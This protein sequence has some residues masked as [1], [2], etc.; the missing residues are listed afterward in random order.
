[1]PSKSCRGGCTVSRPR[2]VECL[3]AWSMRIGTGISGSGWRH[4]L[5]Q[6]PGSWR[7][8]RVS[9]QRSTHSPG[10]GPSR[11][12]G[13]EENGWILEPITLGLHPSG[14]SRTDSYQPEAQASGSILKKL[15]SIYSFALRAGIL[16]R[17]DSSVERSRP[18]A[19]PR[20]RPLGIAVAMVA[21]WC[22]RGSLRNALSAG[23]RRDACAA[24]FRRSFVGPWPGSPRLARPSQSVAHKGVGRSSDSR[25]GETSLLIK[26]PCRPTRQWPMEVRRP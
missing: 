14:D 13:V 21:D 17:R 8:S 4:S 11:V 10:N 5:R 22:G 12:T 20:S 1:M 16:E 6:K 2:A 15:K 23:H 7:K 9:E 18:G 19:D 3:A 25:A 26:R 24:S